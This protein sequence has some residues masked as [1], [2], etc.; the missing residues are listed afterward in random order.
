MSLPAIPD[1]TVVQIRDFVRAQ[2]ALDEALLRALEADPRAGVR[3][4]AVRERR[5]RNAEVAEH[6][7]IERMLAL[8]RKLRARGISHIAGVDEA[9]RGPLAGPVVAAAVILPE[10]VYIPGLNDSK[11]L[12]PKRREALYGRIKTVALDVSAGQAEVDEIDRLNILQA[13]Y[14]A[15]RRALK[16]LSVAPD[17]VLV[18]GAGLPGGAYP[19]IAVVDGDATSLCIAAASVI[20][21]VT[22]DRQMEVYH[23][24]YP[25]YG[26]ASHKGY[27]SAK[28]LQALKAHGPCPIHR[29]SFRG[30]PSPLPRRSEDF[31]IFADG[32]RQADTPGQ[33]EAIGQSI[34]AVSKD[35]PGEEVEALRR[36]YRQRQ[37]SLTGRRGENLAV[38]EL[39]RQGYRILARGYRAAGGE[40][41]IVA[42]REGVLAFVEVKTATTDQFGA[43]EAWVTPEK[44][45]QIARVARAYLQ[46]NPSREWSSRFDVVVIRLSGDSPHVRHIPGAFRI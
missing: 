7:R 37:N 1:L 42:Y 15:M 30:V 25:V 19:E 31:R 3:S 35:L 24:Q 43:P 36:L 9:G 45:R 39:A 40:I 26:F 17:R 38:Q 13:T 41:D 21:K 23:R 32:I 27:G 34:A 20:A 4:L 44:Q 18:D 6:A 2:D 10:D 22:R 5:R 12:S 14:L 29:T 28:H 8:E 46:H 33:L 16:G 11:V